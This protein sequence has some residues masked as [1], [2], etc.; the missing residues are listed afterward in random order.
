MGIPQPDAALAPVDEIVFIQQVDHIKA[1]EHFLPMPRKRNGMGNRQIVNGIGI[2]MGR[3]RL[4]SRLRSPQAG[5]IEHLAGQHRPLQEPIR[6][7]GRARHELGMVAKHASRRANVVDLG[8]IEQILTGLQ[9]IALTLPPGHV[10]P[11][12]EIIGK[13][14]LQR[15][16]DAPLPSAFEGEKIQERSAAKLACVG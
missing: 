6:Q 8:L 16:V 3:I 2:L 11:S 9:T 1:K 13:L 5:A 12:A 14:H 10:A 15:P 7:D 4:R